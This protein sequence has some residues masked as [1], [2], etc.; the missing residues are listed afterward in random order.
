MQYCGTNFLILQFS[1]RNIENKIL[2]GKSVISSEIFGL[3]TKVQLEPE[4]L[5]RK[6]E[7]QAERS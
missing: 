5:A 7:V 2:S 1:V 3:N 6:I 4:A